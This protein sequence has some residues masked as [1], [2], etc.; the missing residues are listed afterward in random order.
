MKDMKRGIKTNLLLGFGVVLALTLLIAVFSIWSIKNITAT[1]VKAV[2]TSFMMSENSSWARSNNLGMRRY[3]KDMLINSENSEKVKQYYKKWGNEYASLMDR[4]AAM[5]KTISDQKGKERI[6]S[7]KR[8]LQAYSSGMVSLHDLI[9]DGKLLS[10]K[11]G[12]DFI[13]KYKE[14]IHRMEETSKDMA[15]EASVEMVS[16]KKSIKADA[17]NATVIML[18][19]S[20]IVILMGIGISITIIRSITG[21]LNKVIAGLSDGAEQV[22]SA[23]GQVSSSSQSLAEGSSEQAASLEETSSSMEEMS[24][25]TRQNADNAQLANDMM[26]KEAGPNFQ[27]IGERME[28]MK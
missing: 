21:P 2:D 7:I 11:E 25:M 26:T 10:V 20:V 1:T 15:A 3:E 24:S 5:E 17:G 28:T 12:N 4:I 19:F 14:P 22:A 27:L 6:D 23:A 16:V 9:K 18:I 8:D 13:N